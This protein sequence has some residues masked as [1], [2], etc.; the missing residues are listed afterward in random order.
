MAGYAY[1]VL[2]NQYDDRISFVKVADGWGGS[3]GR[4]LP[5]YT[6]S[7]DVMHAISVGTLG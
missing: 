1:T 2:E 5:I 6:L 7:G 4:Y 3:D